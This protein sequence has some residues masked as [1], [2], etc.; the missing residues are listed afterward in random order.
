MPSPLRPDGTHEDAEA[1]LPWYATGQLDPADRAL[2]EKH[3]SS[4]ASCRRQLRAER[5]LVEEFQTLAPEIDSG[6]ARLRGQIEPSRTGPSRLGGMLAEIWSILSR[7]AVAALAAAQVALVIVAGTVLL[8]LNRQEYQALGRAD[9]PSTANVLVIFRADATEQ[10]I[11]DALR[12]S[13]ASLVGGPTAADA[14]LL[15]VP[16]NRRDAALARLGSD[17]DVQL[18]QPIDAGAP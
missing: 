4:C 1:L 3:L 18:A 16:T 11:R 9:A 6:W 2:V 7:P 10:D 15:H 5:L 14:Y 13:G 17:D 12:A 8:S